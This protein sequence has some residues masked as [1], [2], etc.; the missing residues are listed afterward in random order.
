[1]LESIGAHV[2]AQGSVF[3]AFWPLTVTLPAPAVF[4]PG[5]LEMALG[6]ALAE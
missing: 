6:L 1:M 2:H 4:A 3:S 5:A